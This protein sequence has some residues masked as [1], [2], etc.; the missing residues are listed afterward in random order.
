MVT[1]P[2]TFAARRRLSP[3]WANWLE[4]LPRLIAEVLDDWE[5]ALD[6]HPVHGET[7][8]VLPV[9]DSNDLPLML[10]LSMNEGDNAGEIPTLKA[11]RG[12]GAVR[13]ERADPRRGV[14]LLERLGRRDLSTLPEHEA[15][16]VLGR[17]YRRLHVP[18]TATIPPLAPFVERWLDDIA[19]R[20]RGFPAPPRF[21]EQALQAGRTLLREAP[22]VT[23]HGDLHQFNVLQGRREPWQAIDPKGFAGDP[24]YEL[25]PALFNCWEP[26]PHVIPLLRDRFYTLVDT[27]ELDE[28]RCRDWVVVRSMISISWELGDTPQDVSDVQ[29]DWITRCITVAK[30]MQAVGD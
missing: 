4:G 29:R 25:A 15:L 12:L 27:A 17:L 7:A 19:A 20:G 13:L 1:I 5:L 16:A 6:G 22:L 14:L 18:A 23:L 9:R 8:L 30:A 2:S 3:A 24:C 11:W 10:K 21:V 28:R 26:G